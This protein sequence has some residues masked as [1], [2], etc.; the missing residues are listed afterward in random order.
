[1]EFTGIS[2]PFE[3]PEAPDL[4]VPTGEQTIDESVQYILRFL[5]QRFPDLRGSSASVAACATS[6]RVLVLGLDCVPP[7]IA[8]GHIGRSLPNLRRLMEYGVW[9]HLRSTD[10]PVTLPAWT[11]ITTGKDPGELGIYGFRNRPSYAYDELIVVDSSH[12]KVPRVWEYLEKEGRS[13]ILIGIPQTHPPRPHNGFTVSDFHD[14]ASGSEFTFPYE[15]AAEVHRLAE[16]QYISDVRDFRTEKKERLLDTLYTMV[17][18]RFRLASDFIVR[19]KWDL[20]MM[21]EMATDRLHHSF[22]R[23]W[24]QDHRLHDP[25][26]SFK[27]VVPDFY[28]YLDA[29]IGS[30]LALLRDDTTVMVVSD[31]GARNMEGAV[32]INE[33]LIRNG[34]L[35]LYDPP[36][37]ETRLSLNMIDWS[38]TTAWGEGGYYGRIFL[39]VEGR[40]PLGLIKPHEYDSVREELATRLKAI[41]DETGKPMD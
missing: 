24:A 37:V 14:P 26:N 40:E 25:K 11:S 27:Q 3:A 31:H 19:K 36:T 1:P 35:A 17:R 2:A 38:R 39:N 18:R 6:R 4:S 41:L 10:P 22:W 12:V 23:Y 34:Y 7:A 9:G 33:W 29:C 21:V 28:R 20:F 15:I 32:C 13:S 16:G 30:L 8:F 5:E